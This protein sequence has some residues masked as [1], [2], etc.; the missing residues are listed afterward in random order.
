MKVSAYIFFIVGLL[1]HSV[2]CYEQGYLQSADKLIHYGGLL[3]TGHNV[4][5]WDQRTFQTLYDIAIA[6]HAEKLLQLILSF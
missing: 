3:P 6:A 4:L 2:C 1:T 5:I